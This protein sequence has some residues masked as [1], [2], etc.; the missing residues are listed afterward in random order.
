M[1]ILGFC[2]WEESESR[3]GW[4]GLHP[5]NLALGAE[6]LASAESEPIVSIVF[7]RGI[8]GRGRL[9]YLTWIGGIPASVASPRRYVDI[10]TLDAFRV[11]VRGRRRHPL[12]LLRHRGVTRKNARWRTACATRGLS[13][14]RPFQFFLSFSRVIFFALLLSIS[15]RVI[16]S[17]LFPAERAIIAKTMMRRFGGRMNIRLKKLILQRMNWSVKRIEFIV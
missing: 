8:K 5:K 15:F 1:R 10:H 14:R 6:A 2:G 12:L 9:K 3:F 4:I 13:I 16:A 7:S 11:N 17:G